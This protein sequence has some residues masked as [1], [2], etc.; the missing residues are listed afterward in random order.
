MYD[1][2]KMTAREQC[3]TMAA[4]RLSHR[5]WHSPPHRFREGVNHYIIS[6]ACYEHAPVIGV[7]PDRMDEFANAL[8]GA[9]DG[10]VEE[11]FAWCILPNHYHLVVQTCDVERLLRALGQLHGR[12][13]YAWNGNE[14][15]RGRKV[16][17]NAVEREIRSDAHLW[18]SINYVHHNPVKHG[19]AFRWQE[20]PWSS[21][22]EFIESVGRERAVEIWEG[23]P[24]LE[25]GKGWDWEE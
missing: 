4:R 1:W 2:R 21:A 6:A 14:N 11:R 25:Y 12:S 8:E 24:I 15:C 10:V 5:P 3:Q 9:C 17:C 13:S 19:Y 7:T 23:Y 18:A 22:G 20:W 16:W